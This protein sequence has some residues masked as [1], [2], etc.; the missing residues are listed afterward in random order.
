MSDIHIDDFYKDAG[1]ILSRLYASFPR[2]TTIYVEDISGVDIP[3]E[4][5]IH[6]DRFLACFSTMIWLQETD[7]LCYE[8]TI[9]QEAIDQAVLTEKG[10]L[11]LSTSFTLPI[12]ID[13]TTSLLPPSVVADSQTTI[14]QLRRAI[15][16]HS[17]IE[18]KRCVHY[19]LNQNKG[20]LAASTRD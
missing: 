6:S 8:T 16:N 10:F 20:M 12:E 13:D 11:G 17:S 3:D 7:Y 9:R 14:V 15:K 18:I 19:I 5:G 1:L 4:F 2:K